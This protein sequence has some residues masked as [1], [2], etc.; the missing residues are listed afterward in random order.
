MQNVTFHNTEQTW[1]NAANF[2]SSKGGVLESNVTLLMEQDEYKYAKNGLWLGKF[3]TLTN[4]TYIRGWCIYFDILGICKCDSNT[5]K[6][7]I[8]KIYIIMIVAHQKIN[9]V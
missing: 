3:R 7:L 5:L 4:W 2:C 9:N 6:H 8:E 1:K